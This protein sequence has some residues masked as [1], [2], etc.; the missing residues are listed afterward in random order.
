MALRRM[1]CLD[2]KDAWTFRQANSSLPEWLKVH[3]MPTNVHLDLI[4]HGII[5]NPH[6]G[7]QENDCQWVG[8]ESWVYRGTFPMPDAIQNK[9]VVLALEGLDTFVSQS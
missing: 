8:E 6:I 5:R 1:I 2:D 9:R 3:S 4:H 7:K